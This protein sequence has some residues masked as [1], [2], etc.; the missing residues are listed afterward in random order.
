VGSDAKVPR[1]TEYKMRCD[2]MVEEGKSRKMDEGR[3]EGELEKR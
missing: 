2:V 3:R 1:S